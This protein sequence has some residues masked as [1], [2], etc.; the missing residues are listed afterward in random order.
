MFVS[1][2]EAHERVKVG[3]DQDPGILIDKM[4]FLDTETEVRI[5]AS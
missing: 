3:C 2:V 4:H 1:R 5:Q